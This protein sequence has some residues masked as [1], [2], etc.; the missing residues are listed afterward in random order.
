[1]DWIG[2]LLPVRQM[3]GRAGRRK[4][5][6]ISDCRVL[7]ALLAFHDGVRAEQRKPVEVLLNRLGG[8]LPA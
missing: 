8:N 1:M 4:P 2:G 7:M 6:V 3:T 5:Q